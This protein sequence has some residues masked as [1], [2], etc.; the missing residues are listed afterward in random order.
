MQLKEPHEI[1]FATKE[2]EGVIYRNR[3]SFIQ[4]E[5]KNNPIKKVPEYLQEIASELAKKGL[6]GM[7]NRQL[8][9]WARN[10]LRRDGLELTFGQ[11]KLKQIEERAKKTG[12]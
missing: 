12:V 11:Q 10:E 9:K 5:D 6:T 7:S 8:K 3:E 2:Q 1:F 4:K